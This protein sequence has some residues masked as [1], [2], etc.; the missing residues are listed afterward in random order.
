M[1]NG[2]TWWPPLPP[3][4]WARVPATPAPVVITNLGELWTT[5]KGKLRRIEIGGAIGVTDT[6]QFSDVE[7]Q[8]LIA[9]GKWTLHTDAS[10][11][12][13][14]TYLFERQVWPSPRNMVFSCN[15]VVVNNGF[16][17]AYCKC[18]RDKFQY[19]HGRGWVVE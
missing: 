18:G 19:Y 13:L 11:R 12:Q 7:V 17:T 4:H 1:S 5:R 14:A 9:S 6:L 2:A 3:P 8:A 16:L 10:G 15:H